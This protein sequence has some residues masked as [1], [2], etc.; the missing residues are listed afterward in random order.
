V[1]ATLF[2]SAVSACT[3]ITLVTTRYG[4][5]TFSPKLLRERTGEGF[6]FA[7]TY[8]T[9]AIYNE[10]DK[11]M[12]GHYGMNAANGIYAMAY[13]VID[14]ATMP[15]NAVQGAAF[16][17]FFRK[18]ALG[19]RDSTEYALRIIKRTAPLMLLSM[20]AMLAAAP[21]IPHMVG[22]SFTE[23]ISALRWLCLLPFFRSFNFSAGDALTGTGRQKLRLVGLT[24]AAAFNF[25]SNLYLIP[26]YGWLGAAWASLAT[27]GLLAVFNWTALLA[28][29]GNSLATAESS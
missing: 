15:L 7:L 6:V 13:R 28:I 24:A 14:V 2:V 5:P 9:N 1:V 21:L 11:T 29:R 16:P 17:R 8:S 23:S 3:A 19:P 26:H 10:I 4:R 22:K 27:D 18:G 20:A 12:L 25:C